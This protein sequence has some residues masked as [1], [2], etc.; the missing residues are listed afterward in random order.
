MILCTQSNLPH[1]FAVLRNKQCFPCNYEDA[2][3]SV[4]RDSTHT[5]SVLCQLQFSRCW[6]GPLTL[7][8]SVTMFSNYHSHT[9][10]WLPDWQC[11]FHGNYYD[12]DY[13][14]H[15]TLCSMWHQIAVARAARFLFPLMC[16]MAVW[17]IF[18]PFTVEKLFKISCP[19]P[20]QCYYL[21]AW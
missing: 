5:T 18:S 2:C 13:V 3:L 16:L 21:W 19:A 12:S 1:F 11:Y 9:P 17:G 8:L 14:N 4:L 20:L 15:F 7:I 6:W 10:T